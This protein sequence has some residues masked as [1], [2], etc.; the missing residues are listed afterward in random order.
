MISRV[1]LWLF[2]LCF[3]MGHGTINSRVWV[4]FLLIVASFL[5]FT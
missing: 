3:S 2:C 1:E 4:L 5:Y